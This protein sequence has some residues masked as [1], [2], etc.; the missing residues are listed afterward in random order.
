MSFK[1]EMQDSARRVFVREL[2][3]S[4][5]DCWMPELIRTLAAKF[6]EHLEALK[7]QHAGS[8]MIKLIERDLKP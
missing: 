5:Q 6:P 3:S 1:A 8:A 7:A 2:C 4:I